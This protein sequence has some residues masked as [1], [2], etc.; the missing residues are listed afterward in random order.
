M[1][2]AALQCLATRRRRCRAPSRR[3]PNPTTI[4]AAAAA[5]E[6][7]R[8]P[9]LSGGGVSEGSFQD[10]SPFQF[11]GSGRG[12]P[13]NTVVKFVP[14]QEAWIVERMG[15]FSR[16]PTA[17]SFL[18]AKVSYPLLSCR[19]ILDPGL[20]ILIPFLDRISYVKS[21][22]E[23]AVGIPHQSAITQDNVTIQLDGVLYYKIMDAYKVPK[24][25]KTFPT[26]FNSLSVAGVLRHRGP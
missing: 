20:A 6:G 12:L 1:P 3:C 21:L 19:R 10:Y 26:V 23:V 13:M 24:V 9:S 16:C 11:V 25:L 15:R 5:S 7:S 8:F 4:S 14:Q 2:F 17:T 18:F 22:K